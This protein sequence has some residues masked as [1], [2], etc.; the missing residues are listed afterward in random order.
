MRDDAASQHRD[1]T[2]SPPL[3]FAT[4]M[5][6]RGKRRGSHKLG[7]RELS[8]GARDLFASARSGSDN[9]TSDPEPEDIHHSGRVQ[10]SRPTQAI[11]SST[12]RPPCQNASPSPA[13]TKVAAS[14]APTTAAVGA[15]SEAGEL[16]HWGLP[17]PTAAQYATECG[18][19][20]LYDW[21][22]A[23]L[24]LEG[25]LEGRNLVYAA[26]TSGGKT[27]GT[28]QFACGVDSYRLLMNNISGSG[29]DLDDAPPA[30][31]RRCQGSVGATTS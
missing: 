9:D 25:V 30:T 21:Q 29:G 17:A 6:T 4:P 26:P 18:I 3:L 27:L 16:E 14:A 23:C 15:S 22:R 13:P 19:R 8:P 24:Q 28:Y 7:G 1:A 11:P 10:R 2:A 31:L 12:A 20:T 5:P